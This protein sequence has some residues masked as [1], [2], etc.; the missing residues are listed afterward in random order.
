MYLVTVSVTFGGANNTVL[1]GSIYVDDTEESAIKFNR[2]MNSS[3]DK[4]S[5]TASGI[6]TAS[7][8]S[9]IRLKFLANDDNKSITNTVINT[10]IVKIG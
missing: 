5:A 2:T 4:G 7:A 8:N 6:L 10:A 9:K 3:G 1:T